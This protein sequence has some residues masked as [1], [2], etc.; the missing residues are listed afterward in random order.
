M[1]LLWVNLIMN[2]MG[3][4]ALATGDPHPNLL[5]DKPHGHTAALITTRMWW[6]IVVQV[7]LLETGG[8]DLG[9]QDHIHCMCNSCS[10]QSRQYHA[11][12]GVL[13]WTLMNY[14]VT[15]AAPE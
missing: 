9:P 2:T 3:A 13:V 15:V 14:G 11:S 12:H 1:Q 5:L 4:L 8:P 7:S 10:L 6:H